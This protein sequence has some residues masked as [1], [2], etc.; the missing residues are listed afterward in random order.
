[1][2]NDLGRW[3]PK[4]EHAADFARVTEAVAK[5]YRGRVT[6]WEFWNEADAI[7]SGGPWELTY[8]QN[9][10]LGASWHAEMGAY[11]KSIDPFKHLITTSFVDPFQEQDLYPEI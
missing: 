6:M 1:M 2:K 7:G 5:H 8:H 11:I 9:R 3:M 4:E 10:T